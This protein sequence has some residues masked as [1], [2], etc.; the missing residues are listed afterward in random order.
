MKLS[1]LFASN[2]CWGSTRDSGIGDTVE[3]IGLL[4]PLAISKADIMFAP[5]TSLEQLTAGWAS[6]DGAVV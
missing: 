2:C 4:Y 6:R 1:S 5:Y 3:E